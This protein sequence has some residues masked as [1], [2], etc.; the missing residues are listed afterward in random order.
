MVT[1]YILIAGVAMLVGII[2]GVIISRTK[3]SYDGIFRVD[4]TDPD[5]DVFTLE[6]LCALG[7]IPNRRYLAFKVVNTSSQ[8]KP[9]A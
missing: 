7:E 5:K 2:I 1:I 4:T 3:S 9:L 6:L 8:E